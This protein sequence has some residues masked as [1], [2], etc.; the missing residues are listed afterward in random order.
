M[1][2][3]QTTAGWLSFYCHLFFCRICSSMEFFT[4]ELSYAVGATRHSRDPVPRRAEASGY[5]LLARLRP[6]RRPRRSRP[7]GPLPRNSDSVPDS[8]GRKSGNREVVIWNI[9]KVDSDQPGEID[10]SAWRDISLRY[11]RTPAEMFRH[12]CAQDVMKLGEANF[13]ERRQ[14]GGNQSKLTYRWYRL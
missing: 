10:R 6:S 13:R 12:T 5:P 1:R 8:S 7:E 2:P 11:I 14:A 4:A 3:S 9:S